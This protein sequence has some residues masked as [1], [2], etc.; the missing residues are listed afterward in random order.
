MARARLAVARA[1][2]DDAQT[3]LHQ[4]IDNLKEDFEFSAD[5]LAAMRNQKAAYELYTAARDRVMTQVVATQD[6][7]TSKKLYDQVNSKLEE[8]KDNPIAN[9]AEIVAT[10][11][12]KLAYAKAL[13]TMESNA[14]QADAATQDAKTRLVDASAKVSDLRAAFARSLRRD[15][16]VLAARQDFQDAR[17]DRAAAAALYDGALEAR[18]IAMDYAY[19]LHRY[20]PYTYRY[21]GNYYDPYYDYGYGYNY[22]TTVGYSPFLGGFPVR[23]GAFIH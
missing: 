1:R 11:R 18:D 12:L 19:D 16:K 14:L 15:P 4:L 6:Y 13:G 8:L 23:H 3:G 20:D 17:V 5:L 9:Q 7:Q 22:G 2:Y 10:A 21:T